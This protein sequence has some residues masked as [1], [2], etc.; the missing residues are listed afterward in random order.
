MHVKH[1]PMH[2]A[3]TKGVSK[4]PATQ[5]CLHTQTRAHTR[6]NTSAGSAPWKKVHIH[7]RNRHSW[8]PRGTAASRAAADGALR[9][10]R[11]CTRE[12]REVHWDVEECASRRGGVHGHKAQGTIED[13]WGKKTF[14]RGL[15]EWAQHTTKSLC[16]NGKKGRKKNIA[17]HTW[18]AEAHASSTE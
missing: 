11:S 12:G 18:N 16:N 14:G 17:T 13:R 15:T 1:K 5:P 3:T 4:S 9:A 2:I 6:T 7:L 8:S 10:S